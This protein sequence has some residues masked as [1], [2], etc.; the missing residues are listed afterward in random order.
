MKLTVLGSGTGLSDANRAC[1]GYLLESQQNFIALDFGTGAFKNLQK[2]LHPSKLNAMFFSHYNHLDHVGDLPGFL[3][4]RKGFCER[5]PNEARQ[6]NLFGP[7]GFEAFAR[8]MLEAF[9]FLLMTNFP[10]N[11]EEMHYSTK[12]VFNFTVKSKPVEHSENSLG[13]RIEANGKTIAYSGDTE[14][15]DEII[16]L[17]QNAD[18]LVLDCSYAGEEKH[19]GHLNATECGEI[20]KKANAKRLLLTHFYPEAENE[21]IAAQAAKAFKGQIFVA[22]D[23]MEILL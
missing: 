9:P 5:N 16:D 4:N 8:K 7:T 17:G 21:D 22:Q 18:L 11:A 13:F 14:Y 19:E 23:L 20:A 2:V 3:F 15:C 10:V 1:S 12:K 6:L